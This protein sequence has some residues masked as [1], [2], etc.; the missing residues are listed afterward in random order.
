MAREI[1]ERWVVDVDTP[2]PSQMSVTLGVKADACPRDAHLYLKHRGQSSAGPLL[3]GSLA[4]L[5]FE[6]IITELMVRG[7]ES[8]FAPQPGEDP[9]AAAA[10]VS[11][12]TKEW[13][14]ALAEETG[15]PLSEAEI[16]EARVMAYHMAIGNAVDPSTVVAVE[17]AFILELEDGGRLLGKVD[18]AAMRPG[19]VLWVRDYKTS[20]YVPPSEDVSKM[21]QVPWYAALL[22]WGRPYDRVQCTA[23]A[24]AGGVDVTYGDVPT[25]A[26]EPCPHCEGRGYVEEIG[27]PLGLDRYVSW[28]LCEQVYPRFL[29][30]EGM[31]ATRTVRAPDGREMWGPADLRDKAAAASRVWRRVVHGVET[32]EWPA[33]SGDHCSTC[34]ASPA[35]PIPSVLRRHAG[36]IHTVEQAREAKEWAVR[37]GDL[38][39][40]TNAEVTAF[41]KAQGLE[42]LEVG[43]DL[44]G[45]VVSTGTALRKAGRNTDWEGLRHAI[46]SATEFG[47]PFAVED[48]LRATTKT[49]FKKIKRE[50]QA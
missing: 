10:E 46:V 3:R 50:E 11:Q 47:E 44:Y 33:K 34:T 30:A 7:E 12:M 13:V 36:T 6:R 24:G 18:L 48:W 22:L 31:M 42:T 2:L 40:A 41:V 38:T 20:F 15:W 26:V 1:D 37:Q 43:S 17:Q 19:G 49:E 14:D 21:I 39:R 4:H 27:E 32:R 5:A 29:N 16:D 9:L 45:L 8:L 35:C 28:V 25:L 23:C